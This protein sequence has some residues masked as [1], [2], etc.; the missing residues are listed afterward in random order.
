MKRPSR[1][2]VLLNS[3]VSIGWLA[4]PIIGIFIASMALL[5]LAAP[6][7]PALA[8]VLSGMLEARIL[9]ELASRP[10][11]RF[12]AGQ[13]RAIAQTPDASNAVILAELVDIPDVTL[14]Q[15]VLDAL[16][17]SLPKVGPSQ[18]SEMSPRQR[19]WFRYLLDQALVH[20][21]RVCTDERFAILLIDAL[22]RMGDIGALPKVE[23]LS[24]SAD[25]CRVRKAAGIAAQQLRSLDRG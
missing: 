21:F 18:Y 6:R 15:I 5:H 16:E 19:L 25:S 14:C 24:R 22:T 12:V 9:T 17:L 20:G 1:G 8:L 10:R 3:Y 23:S 11:R 2:K 13:I 4:V 7:I